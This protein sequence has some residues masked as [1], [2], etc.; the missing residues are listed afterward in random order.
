MAP[1]G[2]LRLGLPDLDRAISAYRCGRRD[3]FLVPDE[4]AATLGGKMIV[5]LLWYG[6]NVMLFTMDWAEEL[7]VRAGFAAVHPSAYRQTASPHPD[8]VALDNREHESL[9]IEAVVAEPSP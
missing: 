3:H 6:H 2:W 1:G 7:L 9:F 5:H 8:I 4:D